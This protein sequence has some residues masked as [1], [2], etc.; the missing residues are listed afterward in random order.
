MITPPG[1]TPDIGV[2]ATIDEVTAT[3]LIVGTF[4][5]A[6]NKEVVAFTAGMKNSSLSPSCGRGDAI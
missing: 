3:F 1:G 6:F 4:V 2:R 5:A